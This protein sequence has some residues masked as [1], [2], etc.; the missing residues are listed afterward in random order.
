[1]AITL[2]GLLTPAPPS[3]GPSYADIV[4]TGNNL[5]S[6]DEMNENFFYLREL[7]LAGGSPATPSETAVIYATITSPQAA[8]S[9]ANVDFGTAD[10]NYSTL[11]TGLTW[12]SVTKAWTNTSGSSKVYN[13]S[14]TVVFEGNPTG[15]RSLSI[16]ANGAATMGT[17]QVPTVIDA[18]PGPQLPY[19]QTFVT[20]SANVLLADT[21]YF[22]VYAMQNS[23]QAGGLVLDQGYSV[24]TVSTLAV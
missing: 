17:T 4:F 6:V 5:L 3:P 21:E 18:G 19:Y 12:N 20:V 8:N 7:A 24:L 16:V 14:A 23:G 22:Q 11:D 2:K 9:G 1:M 10:A 13:V 15:Y